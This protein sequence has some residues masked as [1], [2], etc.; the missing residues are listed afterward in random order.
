MNPL[1]FLSEPPASR[2]ARLLLSVGLLAGSTACFAQA[3]GRLND[4]GFARCGNATSNDIGCSYIDNDPLGYPRQDGQTGRAAKE[5]VAGVAALVK[6]GTSSSPGFDFSKVLGNG[7]VQNGTSQAGVFAAAATTFTGWMCTKDN[8]TGLIWHLKSPTGNDYRLNTNKYKWYNA[9][10]NNGGFS[11]S[12]S[13]DTSTC[14]GSNCDTAAYI[15][16]VNAIDS[17]GATAGTPGICGETTNDWRLPT[18]LELLTIVDSYSPMVVV[19]TASGLDNA[20]S[21]TVADN[22]NLDKRMMVDGIG[23]ASGARVTNIAG[24][25]VTLSL[26]NTAAVSGKITFTREAA[27]DIE[28]FPNMRPGYYWTSD[29]FAENNQEA[30]FVTFGFGT[31]GTSPKS[32]KMHV[33]L[34]RPYTP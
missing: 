33:I 25:V 24:N 10:G 30:R 17:N 27:V 2:R 15:A 4:T 28:Y 20:T 9:G 3:T 11:G 5:V 18:R 6:V 16:A 23:I 21:I 13:A 31:D 32:D 8:V 29:S 22:V 26:A 14:Y 12:N 34:V 7:T 1:L 19:K